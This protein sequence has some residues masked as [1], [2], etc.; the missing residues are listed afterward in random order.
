MVQGEVGI[1]LVW[2]KEV[3]GEVGIWF[4]LVQGVQGE[5]GIWL[6]LVQSGTGGSRNMIRFGS[7][8]YRGK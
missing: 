7:R 4:G 8:W 5:G 3:Q 1:R 6:G 2:F